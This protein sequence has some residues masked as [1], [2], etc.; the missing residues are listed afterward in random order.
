MEEDINVLDG[1]DGLVEL[2]DEELKEPVRQMLVGQPEFV[3]MLEYLPD[4]NKNMLLEILSVSSESERNK[5]IS[6]LKSKEALNDPNLMM[7]FHFCFNNVYL[8]NIYEEAKKNASKHI[9][10]EIRDSLAGF[11][12]RVG[13]VLDERYK[14]MSEDFQNMVVGT[15]EVFDEQFEK[16]IKD[17]NDAVEMS[18]ANSDDQFNKLHELHKLLSENLEKKSIEL[19]E[20]SELLAMQKIDEKFD[21]NMRR[22]INQVNESRKTPLNEKVMYVA[23]GGGLIELLGILNHALH[24][25]Q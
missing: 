21:K 18:K 10:G 19:R 1:L 16:L 17:L 22:L 6:L 9:A 13:M 11:L 25:F 24:I 5:I 15:V 23:I 3:E 2:V 14:V 7:Y 12:S 8:A 4:L 20:Q